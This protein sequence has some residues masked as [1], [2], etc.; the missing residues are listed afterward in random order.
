MEEDVAL[1]AEL[2]LNAY[3]FSLSWPR[4]L[5]HGTGAVNERGLDFSDRLVDPLLARGI[6][7]L[8]T[9]YHWDLRV[10]LQDEGGWLVRVTA[11][12]FV[13]YAAVVPA[14]LGDRVDGCLTQH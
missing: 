3:R 5:P 7:A 12:A 10:A 14:P 9:L 11:Y 13:E 6:R 4:I 8:A 1:M 2:N